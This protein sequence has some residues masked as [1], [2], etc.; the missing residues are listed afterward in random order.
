M[1]LKM[2]RGLTHG[3]NA[4]GNIVAIVTQ[5]RPDRTLGAILD[6]LAAAWKEPVDTVAASALP[7]IRDLILQGM[8]LPE[9]GS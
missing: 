6:Q 9:S 2:R 5:I 8:L 3:G 4:G 1:R 7:Q